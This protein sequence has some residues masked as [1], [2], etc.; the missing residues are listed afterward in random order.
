MVYDYVETPVGM[1]FVA[2]EEGR[3]KRLTLSDIEWIEFSGALP[4]ISRDTKQCREAVNQLYEYFEG[5]RRVFTVPAAPIGPSF[6]Q[7][8]WDRLREIPYGETR[9]YSDIACSLGCPNA[10]R[11]VGRANG[12]NPIPI[13]IPCHRVVGKNG[14]L[15]GF[16]GGLPMKKYLLELERKY[17]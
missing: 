8:V 13:I 3:V 16:R 6:H 17:R 15:T 4:G 14:S 5:D 7:M 1:L 12:L 9:S 2:V 10:C 11:A